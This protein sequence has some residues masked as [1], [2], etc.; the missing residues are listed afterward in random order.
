ME[1]Y[2]Y[3][4]T[5]SLYVDQPAIIAK[6]ASTAMIERNHAYPYKMYPPVR[7]SV[8]VKCVRHLQERPALAH[9]HSYPK[10]L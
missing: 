5:M 2:C 4:V 1:F 3:R 8:T 9:A 6:A 10:D 7:A